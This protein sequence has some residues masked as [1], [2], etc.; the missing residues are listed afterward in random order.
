MRELPQRAPQPAFVSATFVVRRE[1]RRWTF[2]TAHQP[3][4]AFDTKALAVAHAKEIVRQIPGA[5]FAV[6]DGE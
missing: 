5:T 3:F 2:G 6:V 4:I 1:G